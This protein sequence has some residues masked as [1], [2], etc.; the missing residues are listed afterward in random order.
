MTP[1]SRTLGLLALAALGGCGGADP[2]ARPNVLLLSVDTLRRDHLGCYGHE[3]DT[4]PHLDALARTGVVF[5]RA[6]SPCCW[7][8]PSHASMLTGLYPA[9]HGLQDDGVMLPEEVPTLAEG[10]QALGYRT[11]AVVSHVYVSK[12]FDL[13][14]G[15]DLFDDSLI[16]GGKTN[17]VAGQ[18]VERFL[19]HLGREPRQPFFA[20]VHFFDPHWDYA[21]PAPF[22]GRFANPRYDGPVDG[23]YQ[24]MLTYNARGKRMSRAD[25]R[26]S[27]ALYDEE[28]AYVD[29][30]IGRLLGAL[31]ERGLLDDTVVVFTADHGEEFEEHGRIGHAKTLFAEQLD[32]PLI[33]AGPSGL[34]PGSRRSDLVSLVDLAP[35]LLELAGGRPMEG[36]HGSS[37]LREGSSRV[38][39]AESIRFGTEIRAVQKDG[40]KLIHYPG[41]DRWLFYDLLEDPTEQRPRSEDPTGGELTAVLREYAERSDSSWHLKVF[42]ASEALR[43]RGSIQTSGR[44]VRARHYFTNSFGRSGALVPRFDLDPEGRRL[45]FEAVVVQH[46]GELAF[47]VMPPEAAV[48][49][50]LEIEGGGADAGLFLASGERM[51]AG[52]A[53]SLQRSDPRLAG[54]AGSVAEGGCTIRVGPAARP[55]TPP[56]HLSQEAIDR[57]EQLGYTDSDG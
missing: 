47:D 38:V 57:L 19:R 43:C 11:L 12:A 40:H 8:L 20:F 48:T 25:R 39:F 45:D 56:S 44:L 50:A 26:Q 2:A 28:I 7:T 36:A 53:L 34:P 13:Q 9:Y 49:F 42:A 54:H 15:F 5:D 33:I 41:E 27:K 31:G 51:P 29:F 17:P 52:E 37:L 30:E 4:S 22:R 18:V 32:V 24:Q 46:R 35:T 16:L 3:R 10:L 1:L 23:T 14:R 55:R 21:A 6:V